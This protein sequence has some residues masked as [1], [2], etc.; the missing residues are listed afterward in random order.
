MVFSTSVIKR[1]FSSSVAERLSPAFCRTSGSGSVIMSRIS[2]SPTSPSSI[3]NF[4]LAAVSSNRRT[5]AAR[6]EGCFSISIA[7]RS[8]ASWCGRQARTSLSHGRN[9]ATPA[10]SI[11]LST[12]ASSR[13]AISSST[14]TSN[15]LI[16]LSSSRIICACLPV[17]ASVISA[18][19]ARSAKLESR[20]S[21]S[22][23]C[24]YL[25]ISA[26]NDAPSASWIRPFHSA[27]S[28]S[29]SAR[30]AAISRLISGASTA[31]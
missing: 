4:R 18:A 27:L 28:A 30:T 11:R 19:K 9:S 17:S 20:P 21:V 23:I 12:W 31:G 1:L 24:S 6:P 15:A 5:H 10:C 29:A 3:L 14:K 16:S 2:A 26:V 22:L 25:R 8:S 7:S 13:R